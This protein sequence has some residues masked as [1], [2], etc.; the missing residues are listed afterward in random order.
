VVTYLAIKKKKKKKKKKK[1]VKVKANPHACTVF[2]VS[3]IL[4]R[5]H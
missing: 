4:S 1:R 5:R 2:T 3:A